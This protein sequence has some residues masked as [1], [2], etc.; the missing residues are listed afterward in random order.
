MAERAGDDEDLVR[1]Y[2]R[3]IGRHPLLTKDDEVHLARLIEDGAI[4]PVI[5]RIF[6]F[7]STNDALTYVKAGRAKGKVVIRVKETSAERPT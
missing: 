5:D 4:R 3:D 1:L 7:E 6:P 2:L